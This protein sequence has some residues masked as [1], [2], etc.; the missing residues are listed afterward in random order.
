M[1]FDQEKRSALFPKLLRALFARPGRTCRH[2]H[3][4][5]PKAHMPDLQL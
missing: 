4:N 3:H 2:S 1:Q 5:R